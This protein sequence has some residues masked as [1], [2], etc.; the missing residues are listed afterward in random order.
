MDV[1]TGEIS[2]VNRV[3]CCTPDW[4]PDSQNLIFSW[5]PPGQNLNRGYGWTQ[6]W[7]A[8]ADG[9]ARQLV[10]AEEGRHVYGGVVSPDGRYVVFTGNMEEDGDPGRNGSPMALM[11]V[12]D[13]PIIRGENRQLRTQY[14]Q[15]KNGPVITLPAGWE[16]CWTLSQ[17]VSSP[18]RTPT[19]VDAGDDVQLRAELRNRGWL[20]FSA[21]S[22]GGDWDLFRMRPDGS[23]RRRITNTPGIHE[24]GV[25][26]SPNG[27]QLLFYRIPSTEAV[28]NNTYGTFELV[29]ADADGTDPVSWG[30]GHSWA[31]WGPDSKHI[32][33]LTP[34]HIQ[35]VDLYSRSVVREL[36]RRGI[37]SQLVWSPDGGNFTGTANGL[38]PFW[39]IGCLN[40]DTGA[41]HAVSEIE[42]Y[43]CTPDWAPDARRI[44]YARG[45]VPDFGGNAE[46]WEANVDGGPPRPLYAAPGVHFYGA[47]AS[48]D[49][50]Y[51]VFTRSIEDLGK[52]PEI[53]MSIIRWPGPGHTA[54]EP[55]PTRVDLGEGW[56][57]HWTEEIR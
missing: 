8:G 24:A 9:T 5:R 12:A 14:P 47:C 16:P 28:D 11:R 32:A 51:L 29:I 55:A 48:P 44:V 3:D 57:P 38:G 36:P 56:E 43:N 45:I 46:L 52:V 26:V 54:S 53:Q 4:F 42:R 18:S 35:I 50:R 49:S 6:L 31:S 33:C 19:A 30:I 41:I 22:E 15:A 20:V 25:R 7:R 13:A 2:A 37:V 1:S 23:D 21:R 34:R 40:L 17:F 27:R 10:F 39:N